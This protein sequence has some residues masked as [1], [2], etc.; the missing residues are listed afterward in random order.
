MTVMCPVLRIVLPM[1][2]SSPQC[3]LLSYSHHSIQ[4][5][6]ILVILLCCDVNDIDIV[7]NILFMFI[8]STIIFRISQSSFLIVLHPSPSFFIPI[9]LHPHRSSSPSSSSSFLLRLL[10][11]CRCCVVMCFAASTPPRLCWR[12]QRLRHLRVQ[13]GQHVAHRGIAQGPRC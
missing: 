6:L 13:A 2:S 10:V 4:F 7:I 5:T 8:F 3:S 11:I 1:A 9:I 12:V